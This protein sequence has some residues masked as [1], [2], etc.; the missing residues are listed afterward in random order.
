MQ[1]QNP[2]PNS[3][4][5]ERQVDLKALFGVIRRRK[6]TIV[7]TVVV[8]VGLAFLAVTLLERKYTATA[9]VVVDPRESNMLGFEPGTSGSFGIP[10]GG[11]GAVDTEVEIAR[12]SAVLR[13]AAEELDL[14]NSPEFANKA[15]LLDRL[16]SPFGVRPEVNQPANANVNE[17]PPEQ[18][19]QIVERLSRT[20]DISRRGFTNIIEISAT[21]ES[22]D[23]AATTA[24][25]VADAY[26]EEQLAAKLKSNEQAV[27][28]LRER[29]NQLAHLI[30]EISRPVLNWIVSVPS[31]WTTS[32]SFVAPL[33]ISIFEAAAR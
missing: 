16:L 15:T 29:V 30:R 6:W 3:F 4:A 27:S 21:R 5:F 7:G 10:G 28:F 1:N 22:T 9:L 18:R 2:E 8:V 13:R 24:N 12:S 31:W 23:Q 20:V 26:L 14:A 17:L 19:A 11:S 33:A 32:R 25:T